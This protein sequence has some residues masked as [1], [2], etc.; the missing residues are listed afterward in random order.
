[1]RAVVS[2]ILAATLVTVPVTQVLG[3]AGQQAQATGTD[4]TATPQ[5]R[6]GVPGVEGEKAALL[7]LVGEVDPANTDSLLYTPPYRRMSTGAKV[8]IV[9]GVLV[10]LSIVAVVIYCTNQ[11]EL[12]DSN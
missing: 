4:S 5:G 7:W 1:M 8:A 12:C 6:I 10:V 9:V 11:G 2:I 3:Q